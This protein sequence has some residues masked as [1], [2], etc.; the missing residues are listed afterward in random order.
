VTPRSDD[1]VTGNC[2]GQIREHVELL[3]LTGA[4]HREQSGDGQLAV[5]AEKSVLVVAVDVAADDGYAAG[6]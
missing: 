5:P 3:Q 4:R 6:R 2:G 1:D